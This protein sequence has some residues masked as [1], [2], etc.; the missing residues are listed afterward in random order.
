MIIGVDHGYGMMKTAHFAFPSGVTTYESEPYSLRNTLKVNDKYY[1]C[2]SNR[3][4][5][6]RDKTQNDNYFLLTLA[7][8]AKEL[9]YRGVNSAEIVLAV[10]LPLTSF[11]LYKQEFLKYLSRF[12]ENKI[13]AFEFENKSYAIRVTDITIYPQGYAAIMDRIHALRK[14]PSV[15]V[16]DIGSWTVDVLRLDRGFPNMEF[17]R[18]LELGMI[19][20][21]SE[22]SEQVRSN[23]GI[24]VTDAQI[25]DVLVH[26]GSNLSATANRI[27]LEYGKRYAEGIISTLLENGMDVKAVPV[28]FLGGGASLI[29]NFLPITEFCHAEFITDIH[30]NAKGYEHI[31]RQAF[32]NG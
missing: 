7:A 2:G 30:A 26:G 1:V 19:R 16:C 12:P 8:V 4:S 17:N 11:G 14:E 24:S 18:S 15:I 9:E 27:V 5:L 10:G 13:V 31:A 20:C 3:Q 32:P 25:E 6:L 29:K 23:T 21:I 28:I 22:I